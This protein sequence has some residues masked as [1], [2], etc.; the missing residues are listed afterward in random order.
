V[1]G[2]LAP[3]WPSGLLPLELL[4]PALVGSV[5]D[6][7]VGNPWAESKL[8]PEVPSPAAE[9]GDFVGLLVGGLVTTRGSPSA[10]PSAKASNKSGI[11]S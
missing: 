2:L 3:G 4:S 6:R 9:V 10:W 1:G 8:L 5:P 7:A 11:M